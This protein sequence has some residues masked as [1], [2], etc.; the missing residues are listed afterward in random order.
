MGDGRTRTS[1][2]A[3]RPSRIDLR[4]LGAVAA[5]YLVGS[6]PF[7]NIA[8][9]RVAG[10]DLR[11]SGTGTVS[12]TGLYR[13]AGFGPLAAA[14][15]L[16]VAKGALGPALAGRSRP[17]AA[18]LAGGAA[19]IGHDWSPFLR[20]AGGRGMSP[21]LG[22]LLVEAWPG[23]ALLLGGMVVGR[24]SGET[25]VGSLVAEL[26]LVPVLARRYGPHGAL[27]GA[28]LSLP[29]LAKR[30]AGNRRPDRPQV[31]LTR[32]VLDRDTWAKDA[33]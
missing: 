29:M 5:G 26:L 28:C 4:P 20:G 17:R 32:L 11:T 27:V 31:L 33:A 18:A 30:I 2:W 15:I 10:V 1:R 19:V 3:A 23:A 6:I 12:G 16:E 24:L 21:A 8:A 9:R 13:V 14:G 25:A 7:S 22:A